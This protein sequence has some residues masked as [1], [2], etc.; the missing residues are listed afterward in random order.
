MEEVIEHAYDAAGGVVVDGDR[1][2]VLD[3][4]SRNETRLPKGHV[5]IGETDEA[6]AV[7]E[8]GEES[9]YVDVAVERDLGL[10]Q[11]EFLFVPP[12]AEGGPTWHVTRRERYFRMSLRSHERV[13]RSEPDRKFEPRWVSIEDA[14]GSM[15]YDNECEWVRRALA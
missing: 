4:P 15:T 10:Q 11:V 2:L 5:E 7:R 13:D 1:L 12:G 6:A 3:R 8:V 9:G 14:L